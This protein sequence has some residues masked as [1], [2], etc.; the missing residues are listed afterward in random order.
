MGPSWFWGPH[1]PEEKRKRSEGLER[2]SLTYL[3]AMEWTKLDIRKASVLKKQVDL[4]LLT[5][6]QAF[7]DQDTAKKNALLSSFASEVDAIEDFRAANDSDER[8]ILFERERLRL[9]KAIQESSAVQ[10]S[11]PSSAPASSHVFTGA[12]QMAAFSTPS[13]AYGSENRSAVKMGQGIS[14][15]AAP[16]RAPE[17]TARGAAANASLNN[18]SP[19]KN[20]GTM[21]GQYG[22]DM[23]SHNPTKKIYAWEKGQTSEVRRP[24]IVEG[25]KFLPAEKVGMYIRDET[26]GAGRGGSSSG[27]GDGASGE[28]KSAASGTGSKQQHIDMFVVLTADE[29]NILASR[30]QHRKASDKALFK[31]QG[32]AKGVQHSTPFIDQ[33]RVQEQLLRPDHPDRWIDKVSIRPN[34]K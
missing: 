22:T 28:S 5:L 17:V 32:A 27:G 13:Q 23:L 9:R 10:V 14:T 29:V 21:A 2:A 3:L 11:G 16:A 7:L 31:N 26:I 25:A 1:K 6:K 19:S 4:A 12:A 33:A 18:P 34:A 24:I 30:L 15:P 8:S 20:D